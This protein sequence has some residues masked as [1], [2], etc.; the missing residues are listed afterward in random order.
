MQFLQ[1]IVILITLVNKMYSCVYFVFEPVWKS[2][3]F[4]LKTRY[5][6]SISAGSL[7]VVFSSSVAQTWD[8]LGCLIK[9]HSSFFGING[10]LT[11]NTVFGFVRST[12]CP[13]SS[14]FFPIWC[15]AG[16]L[17]LVYVYGWCRFSRRDY[18]WC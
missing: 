1:R 8:R 18:K 3:N 2:H 15:R 4:T 7:Y 6:R 5:V 12:P 14:F 16:V 11:C 9:G 13:R 10:V 17:F